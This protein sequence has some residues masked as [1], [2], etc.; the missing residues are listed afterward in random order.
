MAIK[1]PGELD[2]DTELYQVEDD[3]DEVVAMRL[4]IYCRRERRPIRATTMHTLCVPL[5][6]AGNAPL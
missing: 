5:V 3:T 4:P 1:F 6:G 2:G